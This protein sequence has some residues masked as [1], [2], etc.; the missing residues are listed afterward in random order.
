M[1]R[2]KYQGEVIEANN[3]NGDGHGLTC[4]Y[5]NAVLDFVHSYTRGRKIVKP[6][7]ST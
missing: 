6:F 1:F 3:Y 7:F 2:A 5:C 4:L